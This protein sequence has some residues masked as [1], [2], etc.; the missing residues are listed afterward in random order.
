MI[1]KTEASKL[2]IA[3]STAE[4]SISDAQQ[5]RLEALKQILPEAVNADGGLNIENLKA[6]LGAENIALNNQGY[7]LNFAGK[8]L[9]KAETDRATQSELKAEM[10]QSKNFDAT[11]NMIIRGDNLDVLKILRAN[12]T[13]KIKMI[14]IDPPYNTGGDGFIYNDNFKKSEAELIDDLGLN[15][16]MVDY[17]HNI[18]GTKT[19]SGWLAFMY[20]RLKLARQLLTDDG[21]IFISIDDNEQANLKILCDE[22]F[23][24][25]NFVACIANVSNPKGRSDDKYIATAHEYILIYKKN[26]ALFY[27]WKPD[28]KITKRYTK[29]DD[30]KIYREI[31]LRKTGDNDKRE[32]RPNLFYPFFYNKQTNDFKVEA[33]ADADM[34]GYIKILPSREDGVDGNW[35]WSKDS[36]QQKIKLLAPKY[37]KVRKKWTVFVKDYLT[38]DKRVKPTSAWTHKF[39][40]SERG[41]EQF[42][43]L[44]FEKN[45]FPSPKPVGTLLAM[46]EMCTENNDIILDFFAGSGTTA[47]AVMQLNAEDGGN[48]K[49]I[50]AQID[51]PIDEKKEAHKFCTDNKLAPVISSITIE[52]VNRAG[53][54]I[55]TE[56]AQKNKQGNMLT[57]EKSGAGSACDIGY[58]VF[59]LSPR[60]QLETDA[61]QQISLNTNRQSVAD[62]LYNMMAASG[63]ILTLP[64]TTLEQNILYEIDDAYY[65][66]AQCNADLSAVGKQIFIDG[67]AEISLEKW[68]NTTGIDKENVRILY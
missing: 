19:H 23:G 58:K 39:V 51:E 31:D 60:P 6:L 8:G 40:N 52:R 36:A 4:S 5:H 14:Y 42:I 62:K 61:H 11:E 49:F 1:D 2:G 43:D 67:Y 66:L 38:D 17:L 18:Y 37:M 68:L 30:M 26:E 46:L 54:K 29:E 55:K 28:E 16:D 56:L 27:G 12:Y 7:G 50:L 15:E 10:A 47:D 24:E 48:R 44:N 53:E 64:I 45:V 59:S 34:A 65:L 20:P 63:K 21:V 22:I 9:A 57:Q 32:D 33:N 41:S 35:R 3:T 13:G 25:E